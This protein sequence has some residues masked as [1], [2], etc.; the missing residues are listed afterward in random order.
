MAPVPFWDG[1][2]LAKLLEE[3]LST[4]TYK[5]YNLILETKETN[6]KATIKNK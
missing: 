2:I 6:Y 3:S 4:H 1:Q 5:F